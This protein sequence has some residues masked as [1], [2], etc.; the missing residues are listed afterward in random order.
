M[1]RL[2]D[3]FRAYQTRT[4]IDH[5]PEHREQGLALRLVVWLSAEAWYNSGMEGS[6][7]GLD[8]YPEVRSKTMRY[9][10][11]RRKGEE[12]LGYCTTSSEF[13]ATD[14]AHLYHEESCTEQGI[15]MQ[16]DSRRRII[17]GKRPL[18]VTVGNEQIT[19]H[20]TGE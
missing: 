2:D 12:R 14:I 1:I 4:K 5:Y 19:I 17:E 18:T 20:K 13:R 8:Y 11:T 15:E 7:V 9:I 6:E 16:P 10:V 3:D